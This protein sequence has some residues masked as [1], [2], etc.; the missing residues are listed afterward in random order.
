MRWKWREPFALW[1]AGE[2]QHRH[3]H[4]PFGK[5]APRPEK[6]TIAP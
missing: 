6:V 5:G 4:P 1:V 2:W 3:G